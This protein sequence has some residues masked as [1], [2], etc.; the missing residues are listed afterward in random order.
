[1]IHCQ[2]SAVLW[3]KIFG[4]EAY[5][6]D[7]CNGSALHNYSFWQ[8]LV[9]LMLLRISLILI[10]ILFVFSLKPKFHFFQPHCWLGSG[11]GSQ[12]IH[13]AGT[14]ETL[15]SERDDSQ[16]YR[17]GKETFTCSWSP[18]DL[19]S[20]NRNRVFLRFL[21]FFCFPASYPLT[22]DM[23]GR[24]FQ[25]WI[26]IILLW[27]HSPRLTWNELKNICEMVCNQSPKKW[28]PKQC[29]SKIWIPHSSPTLLIGT[30]LFIARTLFK[31]K[32][33][34]L[35]LKPLKKHF[36]V[37]EGRC[38]LDLIINNKNVALLMVCDRLTS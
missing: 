14:G 4:L 27:Q 5:D 33:S 12:C 20:S 17:A 25:S 38:I 31:P 2:A 10:I 34:Y 26:S 23:K 35:A 3:K 16:L 36:W 9:M 32:S 11:T 37:F 24:I 29:W 13:G 28:I 6:V 7:I 8:L 1:M 15:W 30:H 18:P 21:G 19:V 22:R